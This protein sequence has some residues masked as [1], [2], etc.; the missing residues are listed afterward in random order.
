MFA[1]HVYAFWVRAI[2][3]GIPHDDFKKKKMTPVIFSHGLMMNWTAH[4]S[5]AWELASHGCA[6]YCI[7]HTDFT[8][9]YCDKGPYKH[10]YEVGEDQIK[11]WKD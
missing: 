2:P 10:W 5:T 1:K 11:V 8:G 9:S 6:V 3:E 7:E 4:F